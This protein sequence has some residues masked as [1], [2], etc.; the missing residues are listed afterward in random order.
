MIEIFVCVSASRFH[1]LRQAQK[2]A[3]TPHKIS[4]MV[5]TGASCTC[6]DPS[7]FQTLGITPSGTTSMH[8]PSTGGNAVPA[9]NYDV[10]IIIPNGNQLPF[11]VPN[12]AVTA[13][14]LY[15]GQGFHALIGRD[16]LSRCILQYNGATQLFSLAY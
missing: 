7:V 11:S 14:E 2:T 8:T 4:A 15:A 12:I 13:A 9:Y 3:P 1:A 6:I 16:I 5:D 10:Q